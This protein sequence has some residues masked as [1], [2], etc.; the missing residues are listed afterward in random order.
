MLTSVLDLSPIPEGGTPADALANSVALARHAEALGYT[1]YF[2]A[3]HHN[4]PGIASSATAVV[5]AHIAASTTTIRVGSGGIMLPNHAPLMV[6][7]AFGTLATLH[8]GRIDLG[9]GR[10]PG[11][12]GLTARALRRYASSADAFPQDVAELITYLDAEPGSLPVNAVPGA[13]TRVPVW[14]LGSSTFGAEL[15]AAF[16]LPYAFASHFA[17]AALE[18]A[19]DIYRERFRPSERLAAPHFAMA[20]NVFAADSD[21]E[22]RRLMTSQMQ[23]FA[24]LRSGRPGPLPRPVD[25]V[26]AVIGRA[27]RPLVD[28]ALKVNA[29]GSPAT[30][31]DR[32]AAIVARHRPDEVFVVGAIHD[33]A[34]RLASYTVAA[35]AMAELEA[36]AAA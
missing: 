17:P 25:D 18:A 11:T 22:G 20:V 31:R 30:V 3:E 36:L 10:A 28:E 15:A 9:L 8:P 16:G 4:M 24:N 21:D 27:L 33:P 14:I 2:L 34:A 35:R 23:A 7:E 13:G 26:D 32:L 29:V 19:R 5:V 1:R 12:D 6:A